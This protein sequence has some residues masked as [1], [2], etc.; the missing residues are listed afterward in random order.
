[1]SVTALWKLVPHDSVNDIH[2]RRSFKKTAWDSLIQW[3]KQ[4][5]LICRSIFD[6]GIH[7]LEV[8]PPRFTHKEQRLWMSREDEAGRTQLP[9]SADGCHLSGHRMV[10]MSWLKTAEDPAKIKYQISRHLQSMWNHSRWPHS[11]LIELGA[12]LFFPRVVRLCARGV[13][14]KSFD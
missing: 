14:A 7:I 2:S 10:L 11:P 4:H 6:I 5:P 8:C 3:G 9:H 13:K 12:F 1:M